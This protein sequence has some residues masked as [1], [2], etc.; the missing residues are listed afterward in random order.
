MVVVL[1]KRSTQHSAASDCLISLI[2]CTRIVGLRYLLLSYLPTT[3]D[4]RNNFICK[5]SNAERTQFKIRIFFN[6][7]SVMYK[8]IN[9]EKSLYRG[10]S[11]PF[12]G[13]ALIFLE[14]KG[15]ICLK[16]ETE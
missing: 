2:D 9:R 1:G 15:S 16:V 14:K 13:F 12:I 5:K 7:L 11:T 4:N 10:I 3:L 6:V 8:Q